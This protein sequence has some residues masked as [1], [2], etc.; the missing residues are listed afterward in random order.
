MSARWTPEEQAD[1]ILDDVFK[2]KKIFVCH[3][4]ARLPSRELA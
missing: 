1:A 3:G 2:L 4:G